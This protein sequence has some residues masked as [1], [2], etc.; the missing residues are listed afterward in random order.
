MSFLADRDQQTICAVSTPPGTGGISV[1]RVSGKQSLQITRKLADFLPQIIQS[2]KIYFGT[3]INPADNE[4]VDEVLISYFQ[5]GKSFTG[6]EVIEISCHGSPVIVETILN[7]LTNNGARMADRG[8]FTYR[9]FMNQ[10][11]DLVQAESVLALIE[12][13]SKSS[14]RLALRQLQGNLSDE[15][16]RVE[17]DLLWMAAHMEASIDFSTE[18]LQIVDIE[19]LL[20][21]MQSVQIIFSRLL[22]SYRSGRFLRD[23]VWCTLIGVPNVGKSSLLN[24]LADEDRAIVT[25]IPGTTRDL[26]TTETTHAGMKF[27]LTDTAGL[28]EQTNDPIER[29]G[30]D[31]SKKALE[32]GDFNL[33]IFDLSAGLTQ[34]DI[35]I[36]EKLDPASTLLIANKKD[37]SKLSET[38]FLA[39]F[40]TIPGVKQSKFFQKIQDLPVFLTRQMRL[41]SALDKSDRRQI[42]EMFSSMIQKPSSNELMISQ[43]RHFEALSAAQGFLSQAEMHLKE[44][45]GA[46][47]IALD[48]KEAV[49]KVQQILG[50]SFDDQIMD[51]VFKEFCLGK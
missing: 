45:L 12:S 46:E 16:L 41:V 32:Q 15:L 25:D 20:V 27:V 7:L 3:L 38:Q 10:R 40:A 23:G 8:E 29:M 13:Q 51:R 50:K 1:L 31:R 28:R 33:F 14:A 26:I 43:A 21:K 4:G 22:E 2:H 49:L 35:S 34:A 9:A 48:L 24:L 17:S 11:I 36:L 30:I 19:D 44:N 5:Q 42:F 39:N 18:G 6:E 47:F 37:K